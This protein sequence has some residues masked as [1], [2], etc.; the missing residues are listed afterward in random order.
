MDKIVASMLG[1]MM[2]FGIPAIMASLMMYPMYRWAGGRKSFRRW[3]RD[4]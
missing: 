3:L 4:F 1:T 2:L